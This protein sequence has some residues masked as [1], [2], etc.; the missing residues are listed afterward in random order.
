MLKGLL[1]LLL[2][3]LLA[4]RDDYGYS[5]VERLRDGGLGEVAEGTVYPALAR[6]ERNGS[7]AT[8]HVPS[9]RGPARKYYR[10]SEAGRHELRTRVDAWHDLTRVVEHITKGVRP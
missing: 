10:L 9:D 5:L 2:L 6:L 1:T 8:Y 7:V 4:E 3:A